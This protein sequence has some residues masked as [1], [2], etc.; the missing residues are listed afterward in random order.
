[1]HSLPYRK[2]KI[3]VVTMDKMQLRK[4][5]SR[6][7]QKM[8]PQDYEK[9]SVFILTTLEQAGSEGLTLHDLVQEAQLKFNAE[10]NGN[11]SWYL[12]EVKHDLELRKL[13]LKTIS[14]K[15]EQIIRLNSEKKWW[16]N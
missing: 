10:F 15:R 5:E 7:A 4:S 9:L 14:P 13:I 16:F 6:I 11:V 2:Y 3:Y 12:L 1:M 8:R